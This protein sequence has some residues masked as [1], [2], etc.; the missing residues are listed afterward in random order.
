MVGKD[1]EGEE[2]FLGRLGSHIPIF[3]GS[4]SIFSLSLHWPLSIKLQDK[5]SKDLWR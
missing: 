2:V 3:L 1:K 4:S 5:N